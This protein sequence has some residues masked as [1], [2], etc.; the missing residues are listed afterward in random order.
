MARV[1]K[2]MGDAMTLLGSSCIFPVPNIQKSAMFYAAKL[3]FR[4]VEYLECSEPHV[5][6]YRDRAEIV[7][8][9]ASGSAVFPNRALYGYGYDAY[10]YTE[11]PQM[12]EEEFSARG[13]KIIRRTKLTEYRNRELV[14]ED[15]DGR[16]LAFG[17]KT[18][19]GSVS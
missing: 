12:L 7:L 14:I 10:F 1:R 18:E 11:H 9:R 17:A 15:A 6:L 16:W 19:N 4:R 3:S 2:G 8:L 13:V 5:C